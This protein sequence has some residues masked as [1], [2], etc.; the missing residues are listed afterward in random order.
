M[1][2]ECFR[3]HVAL[4]IEMTMKCLPRRHAIEDLDAADLDQP[5]AP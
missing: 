2:G 3:G 4:G 1:H 5:I